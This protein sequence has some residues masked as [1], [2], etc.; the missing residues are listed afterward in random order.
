MSGAKKSKLIRAH[1]GL[2]S[3]R[4]M[5]P[6]NWLMPVRFVRA[7]LLSGLLLGNLKGGRRRK[8]HHLLENPFFFSRGTFSRWDGYAALSKKFFPRV[9]NTLDLA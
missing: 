7:A 6:E 8:T 3:W 4:K 9:I 1:G 2:F 5:L